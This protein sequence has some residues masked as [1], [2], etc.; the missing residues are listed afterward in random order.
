MVV[1]DGFGGA[2]R[3]GTGARSGGGMPGREGGRAG[4]GEGG[5]E[6][7]ERGLKGGGA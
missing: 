3:M 6:D 4:G 7:E 5:E 2:G 1:D